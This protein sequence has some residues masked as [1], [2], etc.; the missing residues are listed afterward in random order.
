MFFSAPSAIVEENEEMSISD[1]GNLLSSMH[2]PECPQ[3]SLALFML[4]SHFYWTFN[5][6]QIALS[7]AE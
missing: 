2:I 1:D 4:I 7:G 6:I 5:A 3:T